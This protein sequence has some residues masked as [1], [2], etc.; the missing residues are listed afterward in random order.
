MN[1]IKRYRAKLHEM[2]YAP[3]VKDMCASDDVA[4][5]E[6]QLEKMKCCG[7][8]EEYGYEESGNETYCKKTDDLISPDCKCDEWELAK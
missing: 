4:K 8:C 6:G 1:R 2:N 3:V 7:N 5:L